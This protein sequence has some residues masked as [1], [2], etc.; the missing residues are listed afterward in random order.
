M[1]HAESWRCTLQVEGPPGQ[2]PLQPQFDYET[3]GNE[4]WRFAGWNRFRTV[5]AIGLN[6]DKGVTATKSDSYTG[7]LGP[8]ADAEIIAIDK[9]SPDFMNVVVFIDK[10]LDPNP[11][12]HH[13]SCIKIGH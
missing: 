8:I 12:I 11:H 2:K 9:R 10:G 13:G 4:L 3:H 1:A 6:N 5:Y 7:T